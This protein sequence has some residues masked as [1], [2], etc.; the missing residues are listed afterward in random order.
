MLLSMLSPKYWC[1]GAIAQ[2]QHCSKIASHLKQKRLAI[3]KC[4]GCLFRPLQRTTQFRAPQ[5]G[6]P[7]RNLPLRKQIPNQGKRKTLP[8]PQRETTRP[9]TKGQADS[10]H[11]KKVF[12]MEMKMCKIESYLCELYNKLNDSTNTSGV[13]SLS[14]YKLRLMESHFWPMG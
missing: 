2:H 5:R 14:K 9:R 1:H 13:V 4:R 8:P 12:Y 11:I 3:D 10:E 6:V 7:K